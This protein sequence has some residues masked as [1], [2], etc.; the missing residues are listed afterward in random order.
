MTDCAAPDDV[1]PIGVAAVIDEIN[2]AVEEGETN[3]GDLL[4]AMGRTSFV[5]VLMVPALAVVSPLSGVPGFSSAAGIAIAVISAQLLLGRRRRIWLPDILRR[6]RVPSHWVE[7]V[8]ESLRNPA[9]WFDRNT[10]PRLAFLAAAP[11]DRIIYAACIFC[12][13]SMPF[14]ELLPFTSS[15]M[16]LAVVLMSLTLL[17]RDGLFALAVYG[18]IALLLTAAVLL[19]F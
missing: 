6:R 11:F 12:G 2:D 13:L 10:R 17:V 5:P 18:V 15:L 3:V 14:M 8:T 7:R 16:A 1:P 19:I 9:R 4:D